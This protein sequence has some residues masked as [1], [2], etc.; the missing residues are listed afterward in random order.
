MS[1]SLLLYDLFIHVAFI[2]TDPLKEQNAKVVLF[3]GS[4]QRKLGQ[5]TI[6]SIES[7]EVI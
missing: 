7:S 3:F 2:T 6:K 5:G 4:G 1:V